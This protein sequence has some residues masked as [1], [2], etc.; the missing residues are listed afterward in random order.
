LINPSTNLLVDDYDGRLKLESGPA[1]KCNKASEEQKDFDHLKNQDCVDLVQNQSSYL[2]AFPK[3][4]KMHMPKL[5]FFKNLV[6]SLGSLK[7]Q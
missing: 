2:F 3:D 7:Y 5:K 6:K 4:F 1:I